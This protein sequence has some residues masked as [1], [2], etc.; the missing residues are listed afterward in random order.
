M[1][2]GLHP[3]KASVGIFMDKSRCPMSRIQDK[4]PKMVH[5][6]MIKTFLGKSIN[7][8][9]PMMYMATCVYP[10]ISQSSLLTSS[11]SNILSTLKLEPLPMVFIVPPVSARSKLECILRKPLP[12]LLPARPGQLLMARYLHIYNRRVR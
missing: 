7:S 1:W 2:S 9:C 12:L 11:S 10:F 3:K 8:Y 4:C 6:C 5:Y